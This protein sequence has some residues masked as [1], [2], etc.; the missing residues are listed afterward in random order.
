MSF[1]ANLQATQEPFSGNYPQTI[2]AAA[3][4]SPVTSVCFVSGSTQVANITPP[5]QAPHN[6]VLI[7]TDA[8]PGAL[9][10]TGNIAAAVTPVVNRALLVTYEPRTKKY[11]TIAVS[12]VIPAAGVTAGPFT[13]ITSITLVG[14]LVTAL[15]GS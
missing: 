9:L 15:T 12:G 8:T 14:G 1:N 3:T 11:Y 4:I 5:V 10:T 2:V 7:F 13:T 6:L